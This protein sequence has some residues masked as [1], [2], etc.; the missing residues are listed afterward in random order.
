MKFAKNRDPETNKTINDKTSVLYNDF[1]T[2]RGIPLEAYDYVVN[3]KLASN[4][5]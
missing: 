3:G 2:I 1:V 4:G 5:A